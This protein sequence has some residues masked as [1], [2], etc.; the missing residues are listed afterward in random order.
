MQEADKISFVGLSMNSFLYP[1]FKYLFRE[2]KGS[3]QVVIA[4][5][6]NEMFKDSRSEPHPNSLAGQTLHLLTENVEASLTITASFSE[7]NGTLN[8]HHFNPDDLVPA[9]T[10]HSSFAEF[11]EVEMQSCLTGEHR[12]KGC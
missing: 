7:S 4:N 9:V 8:D 12:K 1:E 3:V 10:C 6:A 5:K 11:I 2:K